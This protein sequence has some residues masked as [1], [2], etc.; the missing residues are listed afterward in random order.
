MSTNA[1][2]TPA[3][4]QLSRE[5]IHTYAKAMIAAMATPEFK[6]RVQAA[7]GNA[8]VPDHL[9]AVM[10]R[11][12]AVQVDYFTNY[13]RKVTRDDDD[14]SAAAA[15]VAPTA[16]EENL[17]TMV[18]QEPSEAEKKKTDETS[19]QLDGAF[20]MSQLHGAV[21]VYKDSETE[22]L[23][24]QLCLLVESNV[25]ALP[26]TVPA[27]RHFYVNSVHSHGA[28]GAAAAA[29]RASGGNPM[30]IVNPTPQMMSMME[31]AMKTLTPTQRAT[32]ERVQQSMINGS[33][34]LPEDMKD[35]FLIQRQLAAFM[36]TMQQFGQL[37]GGRGAGRGAG[38]GVGRGGRA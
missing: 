1:A 27:L 13:Y 30:P 33:P 8:P 24:T 4:T 11:Y 21:S 28:A 29:A 3:K 6:E 26:T 17:D 25:T 9:E 37:P 20:I 5:E 34:P 12:E 22:R 36:Q 7:M 18:L 38:R 10:D 31:M 14:K 2:A 15:A 35:M 32:L 23:I 16:L 19:E